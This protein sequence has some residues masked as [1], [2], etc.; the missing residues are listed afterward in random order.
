VSERQHMEAALR[1]AG[2]RK[3]EFLAM[4]AHELRNPLAPVSVAAELLALGKLDPVS[5][6][7]A[8]QVIIRQVH[9]MTELVDDLLDVSRVS[10]GQIIL[11][12]ASLDM[13]VVV[14]DAIEQVRPLI[15]SRQ[16]TLAIKMAPAKA[17]VKGDEKRL[18]QVVA[19]L[20]NNAAKY[21]PLEGT[22]TVEMLVRG[23][24]VC[25]SVADNG[26][27]IDPA[28]Q[29]T[30]FELFEQVRLTS[31]RVVGGLG[32]GLALVR[33]LTDLHGGSVTCDSKGLGQGT[34]F[35]VCIPELATAEPVPERRSVERLVELPIADLNLSILIVDDNVDAAEM[36][37]FFLQTMGHQVMLA[38]TASAAVEVVKSSGPDVCILDI[39]LPDS[40]GYELA[41][42]I[43]RVSSIQPIL[44][45]LTG[46]STAKDRDQATEAGFD[47]YLVKPADLDAV[48]ELLAGVNPQ[49]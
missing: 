37:Q 7:K 23:N 41:T 32:I 25:V 18:I 26:I 16:H 46:F 21:T 8:S 14:A 13:K 10:R 5:A 42:E 38:H 45:A 11:K 47:H 44:I 4:L 33:N 43:R 1:D 29:K 17:Y 34:R 40:S 2:R 20:L 35:T 39:G 49:R 48:C 31:D 27:G 24:E 19:N 36:L 12:M 3:D 9:H 22:I 6:K 28:A 15:E 30:V